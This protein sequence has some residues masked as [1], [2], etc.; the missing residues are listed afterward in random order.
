MSGTR[1]RSQRKTNRMP[2]L[3][4]LGWNT[5]WTRL[6]RCCL[7]STLMDLGRTACE[8]VILQQHPEYR[9]TETP[10]PRSMLNQP[11]SDGARAPSP[12]RVIMVCLS[13]CVWHSVCPLLPVFYSLSKKFSTEN[14]RQHKNRTAATGNPITGINAG[15]VCFSNSGYVATL[16]FSIF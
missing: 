9:D 11:N 12:R 6:C 5:V 2:L 16:P 15:I 8:W 7:T 4:W 10:D 14:I 13:V 3:G 1:T